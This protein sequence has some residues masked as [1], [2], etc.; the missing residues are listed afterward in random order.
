MSEAADHFRS[1]CP[2][3]RTLDLVGDRWSLVI[4]RDV[5][6][7]GRYRY[8]ELADC[9]EKIPSNVLA[10]RLSSLVAAGVLCKVPYQDR[11]PRFEYRPTARA[12][13]LRPLLRTMVRFGT[14]ELGGRLGS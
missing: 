7:R 1:E 8:S 12:Q 10:D 13:A 4:L 2:V 9:G 5:L 6:V 11:P 3:T 14:E